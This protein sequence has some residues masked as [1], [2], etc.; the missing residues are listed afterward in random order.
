[1]IVLTKVFKTFFKT[2]NTFSVGLKMY[3]E[4]EK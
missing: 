4:M 1:M 2:L 3:G